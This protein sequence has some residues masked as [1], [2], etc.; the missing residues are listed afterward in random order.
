[1]NYAIAVVE[2]DPDLL[3]IL[4]YNLK[5]EGFDVFAFERGEH[6]L[7]FMSEG[8]KPHLIVLDVMLPGMSGFELA[9][10]IK[11]N[12]AYRNVPVV[13]LTAKTL[14]EDKL[15][16][17]DLGADDYISKPFS[18]K[19]FLARIRAILR[20]YY[21]QRLEAFVFGELKLY[22]DR[23][24]V[25]CGEKKVELTRAEFKILQTLLEKRGEVV[26]RSTLMDAIAPF[27]RE[28]V[29]RAVDVHI[30]KIRKKL[31]ECGKYIK[32]VRGIGYKVQG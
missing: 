2:D 24:E 32:T 14:E 22:P 16:G 18:V 1:M 31:G 20:R 4:E 6:F 21:P 5:K 25:F 13:F 12:E 19:E 9:Q 27:G 29:S 7:K 30:T 23:F 26:K 15:K 8:K 3:E 11:G 10:I 17:F 28:T